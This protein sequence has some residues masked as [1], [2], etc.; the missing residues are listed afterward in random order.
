VT[1]THG[2]EGIRR[3]QARARMRAKG[4]VE[5]SEEVQF[6]KKRVYH[7]YQMIRGTRD[8]SMEQICE[9]VGLQYK[10]HSSINPQILVRFHLL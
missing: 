4:E 5:K 2:F 8:M 1:N 7:R 9:I 6:K 10:F 3:I